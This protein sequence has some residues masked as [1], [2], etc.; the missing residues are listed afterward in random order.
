MSENGTYSKLRP[1]V[2]RF[3]VEIDM[4]ERKEKVKIYDADKTMEKLSGLPDYV[5]EASY[6][7]LTDTIMPAAHYKVVLDKWGR[8]DAASKRYVETPEMVFYRA[9]LAVADGLTKND[10]SRDFDETTRYVFDKFVGR[11]IFPNTPYMANGGHKLITKQLRDKLGDSISTGLSNELDQEDRVKEQLFACF[12]LGLNDS[13]ESIFATMY[14]AA[15]IQ[16]SIGGTGFNFSSLRPANETIHGTGGITDGPISFMRMYSWVLGKTMNQGGKREGAN[17]FMLDWDHPDIMRFLY[18]KREDGE[19]PAANVSVAIDHEFMTALRGEGE[20]G[21][22]PLRNPHHH[23]TLRPHIAEH[24]TEGQ[25]RQSMDTSIMNTKAVPGLELADNGVDVLSPWIHEGMDEEYRVIGKIR[26][27][28]ICLDAKKVMKHIAFNSWYN[29][30]PG[31]IFTGHINDHNPTHPRHYRDFILEDEDGEAKGILGGLEKDGDLETIVSDYIAE[32]DEDGIFI[33]LPNGVGAIRAT[34]PCGEKPLLPDEACD[35]GHV[36]LERIVVV[37]EDMF[38]GYRVDRERFREDT[39]LTYEILDN[40]ID[41]NDFPNPRIEETQKSNR[42]IGMGFM[43]LANMLYKLEIPY[44]SEEAREFVDDL[45]GFWEEV[46]DEASF[47]KAEKHGAF[48]NFK[49]SH[50][51][52][53]KPKRNAIVRTLAPTGTTGFAAQTTGGMEPEYALAYERT[54]VQGTTVPM[55]NPVLEEK[56]EKYDFFLDGEDRKRFHD[57]VGNAGR[58][59]LQGFELVRGESESG[60]SVDR[61]QANLSKIKEIFVTT[62]DITPED[63]VRMQAIVQDHVDDAISKTTNFRH[64]ATIE[65]VEE[66][67]NLA[68]DLGIKGLTFYRDGTRKGQPLKVGDDEGDE[69][70]TRGDLAGLVMERLSQERPEN[71][72]GRTEK[73][74]TPHGL[75]AFVGLNW[76]RDQGDSNIAPYETFVNVGKAGEDLSAITEGYAKLMSLAIKACVPVGKIIEQLRGIGGE[77]QVGIGQQR[78][79]SLPDAIGMGLEVALQKESTYRASK[80]GEHNDETEKDED[81]SGNLCVSCGKQTHYEEGCEKCGC[82]FSKC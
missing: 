54:T 23:P 76:E 73:V 37:D 74:R 49:Y 28:L 63:H 16:A 44:N 38:S 50:H 61:R 56:L 64:N 67:F 1:L 68:Y 66:T 12:V 24:Y 48:P 4:G 47:K 39:V 42:K 18:A 31:I 26:E 53:G 22:Y 21:F 19:I 58:G 5:A 70:I 20:D 3:D 17:M 77:S 15:D 43:G 60:E 62:Y 35:L 82:G 72:G 7:G 27:G 36:N 30:E 9:S 13:R 11:E 51:R 65:D 32:R 8:K 10:P 29:G 81:V 57:Y 59:S 46:S 25:L 14:D 71:V 45:L 34:N 75:N 80:N 69:E 6:T 2:E 79:R 78:V 40:A 52:N 55:F 33:N 41:Q